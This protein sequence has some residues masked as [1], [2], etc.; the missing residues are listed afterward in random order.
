MLVS[1]NAPGAMTRAIWLHLP[2]GQWQF[3]IVRSSNWFSRLQVV[4]GPQKGLHL[5]LAIDPSPLLMSNSNGIEWQL[6]GVTARLVVTRRNRSSVKIDVFMMSK[7]FEDGRNTFAQVC[8]ELS[9]SG[10]TS[11]SRFQATAPAAIQKKQRHRIEGLVQDCSI[12]GVLAMEVLQSCTKP[13][14]CTMW[15]L[16][17]WLNG[18][19]I[20][21]RYANRYPTALP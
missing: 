16:Y 11:R 1:T 9:L 8:V 6:D 14:D 2:P 17:A 4:G 20:N 3:Q 18:S 13:S 19:V 5:S 12:S 7:P 21:P 15:W 10:V